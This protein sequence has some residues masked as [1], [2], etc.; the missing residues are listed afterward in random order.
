MPSA[1]HVVLMGHL[2]RDPE[3]RYTPQGSAVA[4]FTLGLNRRYKKKDSDE[5]VEEVSFIDVTVW[6]KTAEICAEY[7]KKGRCVHV[8]GY[9]KQDRWQDP[10]TQEK[11]YKVKVVAQEVVFI[12][13]K[14]QEDEASAPPADEEPAHAAPAPAK[15]TN[16]SAPAKSKR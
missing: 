6:N 2:A 11:R 10:E 7:L 8:F 5:L 4:D 15:P 1:N 9:L 14:G 13:G 16:G 12:G 3:L